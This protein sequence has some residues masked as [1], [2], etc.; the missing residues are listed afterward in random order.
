MYVQSCNEKKLKESSNLSK[1]YYFNNNFSHKA[2]TYVYFAY[3]FGLVCSTQL[4]MIL[5]WI[6]IDVL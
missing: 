1:A 2:L 5:K 3:L 4:K 6:T